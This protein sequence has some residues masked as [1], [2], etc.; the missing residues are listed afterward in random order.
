M[1]GRRA[2]GPARPKISVSP[3]LHARLVLASV[4]LGQSLE[5]I[6]DAVLTAWLPVARHTVKV[7]RHTAAKRAHEAGHGPSP[8]AQDYGLPPDFGI[9]RL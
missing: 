8:M 9:P 6:A 1:A 3:E 7:N 4:E 2:P 5:E